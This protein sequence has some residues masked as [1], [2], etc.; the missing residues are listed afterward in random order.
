MDSSCLAVCL[1]RVGAFLT[2]TAAVG[3]VQKFLGQ[4]PGHSQAF[5]SYGLW[6]HLRIWGT[7]LAHFQPHPPFS[8]TEQLGTS[9]LDHADCGLGSAAWDDPIHPFLP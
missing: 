1:S 7:S 9:Y 3:S 5:W 6:A 8:C 2:H 4:V